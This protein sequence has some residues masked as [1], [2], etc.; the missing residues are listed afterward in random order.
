MKA[1]VTRSVR[2]KTEER[3]CVNL[4]IKLVGPKEAEKTKF[5]VWLPSKADAVEFC[6]INGIEIISIDE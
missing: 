3:F 4:C 5:F 2:L 6:K 1:T